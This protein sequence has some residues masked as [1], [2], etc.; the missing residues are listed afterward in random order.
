MHGRGVDVAPRF[1][2][3]KSIYATKPRRPIPAAADRLD[4]GDF[5]SQMRS[6]PCTEL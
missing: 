1:G 2:R 5:R 3:K 6:N 4:R